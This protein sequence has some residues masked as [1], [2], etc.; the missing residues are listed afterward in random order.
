M[1]A[2][3]RVY[4]IGDIHGCLD[5]LEDLHAA[6]EADARAHPSERRVVVYV[7]DYVD[8]GPDS[9]GVLG[10]LIEAPLPGFES[11]HLIG[12]HEAFMMQFLEDASVFKPWVMNGG[13]AT[14]RSFGLSP[15][16]P[17]GDRATR[18]QQQL[19][20]SLSPPEWSFF[21]D[22]R[23]YHV[24][25]D[26]FFAHAGVR[27]GV[28]LTDQDPYDLMWIREPFLSSTSD[29]GKV[30]VHGHTPYSEPDQHSNRVG[31]DTGAVYGGLLTALVLEDDKQRFIQI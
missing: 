28:P 22:L 15:M 21:R 12:N 18:L 30:V 8:R 10:L 1:P 26:Y 6:I 5:Q 24:E 11:V 17:G 9:R 27:P 19:R 3:T 20:E 25:G 13:D 23:D 29:F 31:I 14:L 16:G 4:A 2:G 7:G